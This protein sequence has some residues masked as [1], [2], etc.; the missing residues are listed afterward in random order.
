M[1]NP[2]IIVIGAGVGGLT[3]A[4]LLAQTGYKV[5]V[6]EA[7]SYAGGSASTFYHKGY[8]FDSGATVAG[9][10]Q[11]NGPH[12]VLGKLL[13]IEWPIKR[14]EPAWLVHLPDRSV[15]L[16]GDYADILAKFPETEAFWQEQSRIAEIAWH[17]S[18]QGLPWPPQDLP[19]LLQ[20][21]KV[22]LLNFPRDLQMLPY[23][24][25]TVKQWASWKGLGKN[26]GFLR[27]LDA[28]LLISAQN[29]SEN[30]NGVYGATALDLAR[31]GVYNVAEGMG[32]IAETLVNKLRDLDGEIHFRQRVHRIQVSNGLVSGVYATKGRRSHEEAFYPADFVLANTTPWSLDKLLGENSTL[33][34]EIQQRKATQGAFILH[35]GV[36]AE[37]LPKNIPDHHQIVSSYEGAMGE[38][39]TL[40]LSISPEWDKSRAPEGKRAVTVST[41]TKV[42]QWWDLLAKDEVA[43]Q[44]K[45]HEYTERMIARID[46]I[47]AGFK[48]AVS[49][50]MA[51]SPVTYE[52]Y[53]LRYQGMVGGFPQTSLFNARSPKTGTTNLRLVGDSIFPGQ[54]TAGVTLG[55]MRVA[56]DVMRHLP[57]SEASLSMAEKTSL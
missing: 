23:L 57:L 20:L 9:G 5:T 27:F 41:H 15:A 19:E 1:K 36:D 55:G 51:G 47:L 10:F 26:R 14:H 43:Y 39:E 21:A 33:K 3:A 13:D 7:Q 4:A 25:A 2:Q 24:F 12:A 22:G 40:Y 37:K 16:T 35:L 31:Q 56:K 45:K 29:T 42:Q 49:F 53:T 8:R 38:G 54:S 11:P 32:G 30:V 34:Q 46:S 28:S 17:L 44:A 18:A 52:F 6:L 50:S 48:D